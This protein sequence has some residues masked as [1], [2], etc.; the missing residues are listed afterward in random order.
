MLH[1]PRRRRSWLIFDVGQS[2]LAG[3]AARG[4]LTAEEPNRWGIH[5]LNRSRPRLASHILRWSNAG[6]ESSVDRN[7]AHSRLPDM[8][9]MAWLG[10]P[11]D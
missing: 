11:K 5:A 2:S 4:F 7:L 3:V 6:S 9:G 1:E 10:N 8:Q